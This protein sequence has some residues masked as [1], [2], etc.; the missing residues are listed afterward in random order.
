MKGKLLLLSLLLLAIA[1]SGC[2]ETA[3]QTHTETNGDLVGPMDCIT[4]VKRCP[5]GSYVSRNPAL[6]CEFDAC[7]IPVEEIKI[8]QLGIEPDGV[9]P[10]YFNQVTF[11][12]LVTGT[13]ALDSLRLVEADSEG[14]IL[15]EIGELKDDGNSPDLMVGD[16]IYSGSFEIAS[17]EKG[18]QYYLAQTKADTYPIVYA[19]ELATLTITSFP[20]GPA[21][22]DPEFLVTDPETGQEFYSNE[23]LVGFKA[24][25]SEERIREIVEAENASV[26]GTIL[27]IGTYQ[28][29]IEGDGTGEAVKAAAEAFE[30]YE[31]VEY[32]EP[33]HATAFI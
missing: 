7:P 32:A 23:L 11:T 24:N 21:F 17:A 15:R 8:W 27:S 31:E 3:D 5:D 16:L 18:K 14:N 33:N 6:D 29:Q 10:H 2:V 4:D 22:S 19:S 9:P 20:I 25:T 30:A 26:A 1:L 12:V 28:L 13:T